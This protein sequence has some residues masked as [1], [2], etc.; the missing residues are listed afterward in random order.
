M[1]D[2]IHQT[3]AALHPGD[4]LEVQVRPDGRLALL[5]ERGVVV[6][7]IAAGWKVPGGKVVKHA[8]VMAVAVWDKEHSEPEYQKR[9]KC[10]RWEV[11]VPTL[12][13][14]PSV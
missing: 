13:L 6:G 4:R 3:V 1:G 9:L 14:E 2:P 7:R 5:N 12:V 10:D 11:V 8:T